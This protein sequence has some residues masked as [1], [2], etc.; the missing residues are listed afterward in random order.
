LR[1]LGLGD[2]TVDTYVDRA[3]QFPG[4]NAV[5]VAVMTHRLG[6]DS[7]YLG[8]VG[9]DPGGALIL[10]ALAAEG[11][12]T[13]RCRRR[14]GENARA[15][16]GHRNGDRYFIKSTPGVRARYDFQ[17]ADFSYMADF[18]AI[19]TSIY[20]ELDA[21]LPAI[22]AKRMLSFDFSNRWTTDYLDKTL[23]HCQMAFM[24]GADLSDEEASSLLRRCVGASARTAVVT[25]GSRPAMAF[26][27]GIEAA[28]VA[29]PTEVVDTLGAGDAFISAFLVAML[30][31]Q[32]LVSALLA[33]AVNAAAACR[34]AGAFGRAIS[35][36]APG[37]Q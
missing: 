34:E 30:K 17:P 4:G 27:A 20:S 22:R 24:S 35:W 9:T 11:V 14:E 26:Q 37:Q 33:G 36:G 8:C 25:R 19:H 10:S 18:D 31:E 21:Y 13:E 3:Q 7:H 29:L 15:Y 16:I 32:S 28:Q 6:A 1:I 5:N 23:P 2:N 12:G